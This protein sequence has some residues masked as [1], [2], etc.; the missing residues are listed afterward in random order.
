MDKQI[1]EGLILPTP[2]LIPVTFQESVKTVMRLTASPIFG[3]FFH[4]MY[5]IINAAVLGHAD[6]P[7]LLGSAGLGSLTVS[8]CVL[9]INAC[10]AMGSST[11]IS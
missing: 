4:P 11:F 2:K 5:L 1:E 6:D 8:I 3:S 7:T 9:S 10:F